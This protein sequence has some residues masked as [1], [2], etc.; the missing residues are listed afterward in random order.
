MPEIVIIRPEV[1]EDVDAIRAVNLAAFEG[2][3]YSHQTEHLI[4]AALRRD[5]ALE[6]SLVA[7]SGERVVGHIAFSPAVLGDVRAGWFL[8]GPVAVLPS[9]QHRGI[10]SALVE[11][12]LSALRARRAFGCVLVGDPGFYHRFGFASIPG[13]V[14]EGVP[15]EY[16]LCLPFGGSAPAGSIQAHR[17][18]LVEAE[19]DEAPRDT[20]GSEPTSPAAPG[21]D[22]GS[23]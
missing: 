2:H 10:G 6:L 11:A 13:V 17:A 4:V 1:A 18:F 21:D 16:V 23:A 20:T 3:P 9:F 7:V 15:D 22:T 5:D 12:G 8:V 19:G 14:Y